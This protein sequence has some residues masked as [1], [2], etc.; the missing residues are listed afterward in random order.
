[1][2]AD[3][4]VVGGGYAGLWTALM[5]AAGGADVVLLEAGLCGDGAS[6]RNGGFVLT[7]WSKFRTLEHRFGADEALA[8]A[9]ASAA[10]VDSVAAFCDEHEVWCRRDGWLWTATNAAQVGAWEPVVAAL[11]RHGETPF[12]E[13]APDEVALRAGSDRHLAGV[14]EAS[15]ATVQPALLAHALRR[16]ALERGV[17]IFERSP[18]VALDRDWPPCVRTGNGSVTAERVVISTGAWAISVR[19]LRRAL[20]VV[21]S[22]VVATE[23]GVTTV[24]RPCV[25]DARLLVNY[26]RP[27]HDGR[28]VLGK[29]GGTLAYGAHLQA[30]PRAADVEASLR[31]LFPGLDAPVTASW[32]G[33]VDRSPDGVPF[34]TRLDG[35]DDLLACAGFSGNGVGPS[36]LIAQAIAA[37]VL[38]GERSP[39]VTDDPARFPPEPVRYLGGRAVQAAVR[40]QERAE[41][42]CVRPGRLARFLAGFAP[43]TRV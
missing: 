31:W 28:I 19:E 13:L 4:C 35:R 1:V 25:S 12:A 3:V 34:V 42:T 6:G 24:E 17:R 15:A 38:R 41:D 33:P 16:V 14:W 22:D 7:W 5:L 32:Q 9:R 2:R 8:L 21:S 43:K 23:P 27:T 40:A 37:L 20:V 10:S 39:L 29:G 11:V 30:P 26:H 18:A 36:H